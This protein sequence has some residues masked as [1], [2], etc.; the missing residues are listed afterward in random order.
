MTCI[1]FVFDMHSSVPAVPVPLPVLVKLLSFLLLS[2]S[3]ISLSS[4]GKILAKLLQICRVSVNWLVESETYNE[5]M[6]EDDFEVDDAGD[7]VRNEDFM[8]EEDY[9]DC[10][11]KK[12]KKKGITPKSCRR[13]L[14]KTTLLL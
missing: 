12:V 6:W 13:L 1:V 8:S 9:A 2:S 10:F 7:P 11:E 14:S 4:P 3:L 5:W